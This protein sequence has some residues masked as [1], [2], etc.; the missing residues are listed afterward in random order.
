M[1]NLIIIP[2]DWR[3][4]RH[5]NIGSHVDFGS[6]TADPLWINVTKTSVHSS[7][8]FSW[9]KILFMLYNYLVKTQIEESTILRIIEPAL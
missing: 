7:T 3:L 5:C 1:F 9:K 2:C 4:R 8:S 6:S